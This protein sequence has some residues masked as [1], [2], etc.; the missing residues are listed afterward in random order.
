VTLATA[1]F[2]VKSSQ[3]YDFQPVIK[4]LVVD[5]CITESG[6]VAQAVGCSI[7]THGMAV[8]E[9]LLSGILLF[10]AAEGFTSEAVVVVWHDGCSVEK[11]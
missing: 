11:L 10:F 7:A 9:A 1:L 3:I 6:L 5:V 8:T 4:W 2:S